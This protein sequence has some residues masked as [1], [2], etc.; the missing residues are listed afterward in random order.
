MDRNAGIRAIIW[1]QA[2]E[3][4]NE[5]LADATAAWDGMTEYEKEQTMEMYNTLTS[6][7]NHNDNSKKN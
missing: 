7:Q 2:Y 1:L 3:G 5:T 4:I 6:K